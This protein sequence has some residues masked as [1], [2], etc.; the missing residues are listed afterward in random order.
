MK[1]KRREVTMLRRPMPRRLILGLLGASLAALGLGLLAAS[2]SAQTF[3][4]PV[5]VI[6]PFAPGGASDI[7]ARLLGP[8]LQEAIGQ[9][10]VIEN[11]PGAGGNIGAE[12]VAKADKDGHMLLLMDVSP[13]AISPT[14]IPSLS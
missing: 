7:L 10:V 9:P 12:I 11:K 8:K 5:R 13:L 1:E 3:T 2:A 6:V 14:L 4:K